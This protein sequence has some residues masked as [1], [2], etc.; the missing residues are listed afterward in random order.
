MTGKRRHV[1]VGIF[2]SCGR[3]PQISESI[4]LYIEVVS[5][6]KMEQ[7]NGRKG[8]AP[9]PAQPDG[10]KSPSLTMSAV[11]ITFRAHYCMHWKKPGPAARHPAGAFPPRRPGGKVRSIEEMKGKHRSRLHLVLPLVKDAHE[12]TLGDASAPVLLNCEDH[13][14]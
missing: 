1:K 8:L 11:S 5:R 13:H 14:V 7:V 3:C 2:L 12:R 4:E 10:D 9:R 6:E